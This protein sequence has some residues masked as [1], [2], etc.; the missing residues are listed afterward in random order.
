MLRFLHPALQRMPKIDR[1]DGAGAEMRRAAYAIL[2]EY[3]IAYHCPEVRASHIRQMI[4][5]YGHL[6]SALEI[7]CQ[8]GI[9]RDEYKL[10]ISERLE[11][12]EE[13]IMK[14]K[15]SSSAQ[16]QERDQC[17]HQEGGPVGDYE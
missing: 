8:Q 10:P 3:Y 12:I 16:R 17:A 6:V 4:G 9:L 1:I 5:W 13:G 15:N 2:R 7:C 11:R 14:W